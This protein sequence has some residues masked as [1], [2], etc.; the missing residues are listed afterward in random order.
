VKVSIN[1]FYLRWKVPD[2]TNGYDVNMYE[3]EI[4]DKNLCKQQS[5]AIELLADK[6][7]LLVERLPVDSTLALDSKQRGTGQQRNIDLF[8]GGEQLE[9]G[10]KNGG[11]SK[12][13]RIIKHRDVNK[14]TR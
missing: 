6:K 14:L 3:V 1:S 8:L 2:R 13:H 9:S 5:A 11:V 12:V 4:M 10:E 7:S